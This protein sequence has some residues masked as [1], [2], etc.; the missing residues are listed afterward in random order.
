VCT[1]G[2]ATGRR[3]HPAQGR[4]RTLAR[5]ARDPQQEPN[6]SLCLPCTW[7]M[8]SWSKP[9]EKRTAAF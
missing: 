7:R 9:P 8:R 3:R 1:G 6:L 4:A 2:V 5:P